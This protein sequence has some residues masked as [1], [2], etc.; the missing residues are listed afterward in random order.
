LNNLKNINNS[1]LNNNNLI[2]LTNS[3]NMN[4][5][6]NKTIIGQKHDILSKANKEHENIT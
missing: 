6:E 4:N 5:Y 2:T 3:V 1:K